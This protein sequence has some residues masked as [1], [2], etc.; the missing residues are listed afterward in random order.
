M[1]G[2]LDVELAEAL[3]PDF[4]FFVNFLHGSCPPVLG[5]EQLFL[6][7]AQSL[8]SVFTFQ[9]CRSLREVNT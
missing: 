6:V 3:T 1:E 8:E 7:D 9:T 4:F 5:I 2:A